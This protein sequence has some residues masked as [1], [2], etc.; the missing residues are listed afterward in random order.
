V[1]S[2]ADVLRAFQDGLGVSPMS[3]GLR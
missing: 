1:T 2:D 3:A